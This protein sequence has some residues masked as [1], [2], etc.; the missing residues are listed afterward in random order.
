VSEWL[1]HLE[2]AEK[3]LGDYFPKELKKNLSDIRGLI[4]NV[5]KDLSS[6]RSLFEGLD[7][8]KEV[9]IDTMETL[10]S[11]LTNI[12]NNMELLADDEKT[13]KYEDAL[14]LLLV[15]LETLPVA[16]NANL[17]IAPIA[18]VNLN[19]LAARMTTHQIVKEAALK[20]KGSIIA[21]VKE[22]MARCTDEAT[23]ALKQG[24][25][26]A[27]EAAMLR[28]KKVE[29]SIAAVPELLPESQYQKLV[30]ELQIGITN[31]SRE[32]KTRVDVAPEFSNIN[33]LVDDI[34]ALNSITFEISSIELHSHVNKEINSILNTLATKKGFDF[35]Q[36]GTTMIEKGTY[37]KELVEGEKYPQFRAFLTGL[38][39]ELT[40]RMT[41][42]DAIKYL[43][44]NGSIN[45]KEGKELEAQ[46]DIFLYHFDAYLKRFLLGVPP[47]E[48]LV[49]QVKGMVGKK[50]DN[51]FA[52][53]AEVKDS[54]PKILA[55][56]FAVWSV[57]ASSSTYKE[58]KKM[59]CVLKP[60]PV[61]VLSLLRLLEADS[62][63]WT[64]YLKEWISGT[65]TLINHMVQIGTGEGKSVILGGMS[66][67][68]AL[69]GFDV[70]CACY[71]KYLSKRDLESFSPLFAAF[72]V[73]DRIHYAT[74]ADLAG[75]LINEEV[76]IREAT[77]LWMQGS[78]THTKARNKS[79]RVKILLIDEVDVFFDRDFYGSSYNPST[80]IRD[81]DI[82]EIMEYIWKNRTNQA[83][84]VQVRKQPPYIRLQ[85][86]YAKFLGVIS[87]GVSKMVADVTQ[88]DNPPYV[89]T[90][91]ETGR[92][93][94]GYKEFGSV[95]TNITYGYKTAFAYLKEMENKTIS[96]ETAGQFLGLKI[97]CGQFS[98]AELPG[99]KHFS[100]IL[101]VTGT[102]TTLGKFEQSIL[103]DDYKVTK[104]TVTPSIYGPSKLAFFEKENV[105]VEM[106]EAR[107]FQKICDEILDS[108]K[109]GRAVLVFFAD[110][111][112]LRRFA[113]SGY[114]KGFTFNDFSQTHEN[115]DFYVRKAVRA[116]E[117]SFLPRVYGRG[118][119]F[120]CR[121]QGVEDA[122]GVHVIQTF[123]S[124]E[125]SEEVQI[126]GRTARQ[127]RKGLFSMVLWADDLEREFKITKEE[128]E[129]EKKGAGLYAYL[130]ERRNQ[131]FNARANDRKGIIERSL[132]AHKRS[133]NY[134]DS[135]KL[136][137]SA[138]V[139]ARRL[140]YLLEHNRGPRKGKARIMCLSDATGSMKPVWSKAK[141][142]IGEMVHRITAI[143]GEGQA[144]LKWVAYRDYSDDKILETSDWED[145]PPE[146][147]K[148]IEGIKCGGGGDG[149]EAVEIAL[150]EANKTEGVTRAIL[151]ADAEPHLEGKGNT[152]IHHKKVLDTDYIEEAKRLKEKGVP[153]YCFYMNNGKELVES[154]TK[155]AEIT[156]GKAALFHDANTLIDVIAENVLDD[157]GGDELVQVYRKTY[158]S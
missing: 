150:E 135:F 89:V 46:Y 125:L 120:V 91:D 58:T 97:E 85:E 12:Q 106:D 108:H 123:L 126:K 121:D 155:I 8:T 142:Q 84:L 119:D 122:G 157:L 71:S 1:G 115:I 136:K 137:N 134:R 111:K 59:E 133:I 156:G 110:D 65:R 44:E 127:G 40:S 51:P 92:S 13:L 112:T 77:N 154:F 68:L 52:N 33:W 28:L 96:P 60:H 153:V 79:T 67:F 69:L 55:G 99:P 101:G 104:Q 36:L 82:N 53:L 86:K 139:E 90:Q 48:E 94:I 4:A 31:Q 146:L 39:N 98:Y 78:W 138:E 29:L 93:V 49:A 42:E 34:L 117:I 20:A 64:Q 16:I 32:V 45:E 100:C 23:A 141:V 63:T 26:K 124:E 21:I 144:E 88:F 19:N 132:E 3:N 35:F 18:V 152:V 107:Y 70:H 43:K 30:N 113:T 158:H 2:A 6:T 62:S 27:L 118:M 109:K 24:N 75:T 95:L 61:Q 73:M 103:K 149:P 38:M 80:Y 83:Q 143:A 15:K 87:N 116:K 129:E 5:V 148:F 22:V 50:K 9:P 74:L 147:M 76:D 54:V 140:E 14:K 17:E 105:H 114:G 66:V 151:I 56:I 10:S 57:Q 102:L 145:K 41:V 11:T 131:H 72:G 37:G 130:N 25:L 81:K 47:L 7:L 128:L